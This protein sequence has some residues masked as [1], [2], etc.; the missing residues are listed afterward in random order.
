MA[1]IHT[2]VAALSLNFGDATG[3]AHDNW[4]KSGGA[5]KPLI[6]IPCTTDKNLVLH[7]HLE[8]DQDFGRISGWNV[9]RRQYQTPPGKYRYIETG[10][11]AGYPRLLSQG[12]KAFL[13][14][15]MPGWN[16]SS[17]W[18]EFNFT[19]QAIVGGKGRKQRFAEAEEARKQKY[20]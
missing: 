1:D 16:Q 6:E 17:T 14:R 8:L 18:D 13:S 7:V 12:E 9:Q 5:K 19:F 11:V 3:T 10:S 2:K 4:S 20:A 15:K